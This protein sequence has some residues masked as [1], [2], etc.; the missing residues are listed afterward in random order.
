MIFNWQMNTNLEAWIQIWMRNEYEAECE[1]NVKMNVE[2]LVMNTNESRIWM[3]IWIRK[4]VSWMRKFHVLNADWMRWMLIDD[5]YEKRREVSTPPSPP[6]TS[7]SHHTTAFSHTTML[8]E[9]NAS[10]RDRHPVEAGSP[11]RRSGIA[12]TKVSPRWWCACFFLA[13]VDARL[14]LS[15]IRL[16]FAAPSAASWSSSMMGLNRDVTGLRGSGRPCVPV[17][18]RI[19]RRG[20]LV[21]SSRAWPARSGCSEIGGRK[22]VIVSIRTFIS[23][24]SSSSVFLLQFVSFHSPPDRFI[25]FHSATQKHLTY[26]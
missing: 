14:A 24:T 23:F 8:H 11:F 3:R 10:M 9:S 22:S 20:N 12:G 17:R 19:Q 6:P 1:M 26:K 25:S 15:L 13:L 7:R 4:F 21:S 5:E 18:S 16:A 2:I